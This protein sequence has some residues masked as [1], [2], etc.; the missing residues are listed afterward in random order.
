MEVFYLKVEQIPL[1]PIGTNCYIVSKD[2]Q[3]LI[4]DPGDD[5]EIVINY[6]SDNGL[7]H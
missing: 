7:S 6:L 1:G 4:I 5:A 3:A 2:R